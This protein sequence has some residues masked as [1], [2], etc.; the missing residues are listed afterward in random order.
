MKPMTHKLRNKIKLAIKNRQ[1]ISDLIEGVDIKG[2]NL[3]YAIIKRMDRIQDDFSGATFDYCVFGQSRERMNW[4]GSIAQNCR[5]RNARFESFMV[6]RGTDFRGSSFREAFLPF[7]TC[8][9]ADFRRVNWCDVT[10]Q[11]GSEKMHNAKFS[12][13]LIKV[14]A[15]FMNFKITVEPLGEKY[16]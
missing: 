10:L 16:G 11:L 6:F 9:K 7:M 12:Y 14:L 15:K 13:G 8:E 5:F 1:D 4:S 2:E 3:S